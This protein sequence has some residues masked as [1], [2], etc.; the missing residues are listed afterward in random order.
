M[1]RDLGISSISL[2]FRRC[3]GTERSGH[4]SAAAAKAAVRNEIGHGQVETRNT[5]QT[6]GEE[7]TSWTETRELGLFKRRQTKVS[8][9]FHHDGIYHRCVALSVGQQLV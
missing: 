6:T 9:L 4:A 1:I 2:L 3:V 5:D 7:D 8:T